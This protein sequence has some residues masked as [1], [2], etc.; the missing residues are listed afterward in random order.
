MKP[1]GAEPLHVFPF[2]C[3]QLDLRHVLLLPSQTHDEL[4]GTLR[5]ACV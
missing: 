5:K 3:T 2:Q 4:F 1:E